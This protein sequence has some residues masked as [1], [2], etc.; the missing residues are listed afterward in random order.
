MD[1]ARASPPTGSSFFSDEAWFAPAQDTPGNG[2]LGMSFGSAHASGF[3]M[4]FC[5][6]SVQFMSYTIDL[7]THWYLGNRADGQ[8]INAKNL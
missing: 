7:G 2:T 8:P 6:G 4:G 5:D 1:R 3:N